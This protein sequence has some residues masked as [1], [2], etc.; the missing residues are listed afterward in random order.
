MTVPENAGRF[1]GVTGAIGWTSPSLSQVDL[2]DSTPTR[3]HSV[4]HPPATIDGARL[5]Q[6]ADVRAASPTGRTKHIVQGAEFAGFAWL[7]VAQYEN[8]SG[9]Y[10]FYCDDSWNVVTDTQHEDVQHAIEQARF[11]FGSIEFSLLPE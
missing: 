7:A 10:L 9:V 1:R 6:V 2:P 4:I 11:E 8:E 3:L 5:L